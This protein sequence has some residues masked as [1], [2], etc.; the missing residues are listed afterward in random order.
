MKSPLPHKQKKPASS[1]A[2]STV[3]EIKISPTQKKKSHPPIP[4]TPRIKKIGS[5]KERNAYFTSS[6]ELAISRAMH[7][8]E[9]KAICIYPNITA[10][11]L[12]RHW[13]ETA[14]HAILPH[15]HVQI[16]YFSY[17]LLIQE[18]ISWESISSHSQHHIILIVGDGGQ[19]LEP[20]FRHSL[21]E[22]MAHHHGH[23]SLV[24]FRDLDPEPSLNTQTIINYLSALAHR[25]QCE[26]RAMNGHGEPIDCYRHPRLL[27]QK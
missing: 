15:T 26:L 18:E 3:P 14:L 25:H 23:H 9:I 8:S 11:K 2:A 6:R 1:L 17:A 22:L 5:K 12:A 7:Q 10:G 4:K 27:L 20:R 13:M 24:L 19:P 21:H 16:E